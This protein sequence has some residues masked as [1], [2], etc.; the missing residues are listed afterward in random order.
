MQEGLAGD[1][2]TLERLLQ[3]PAALGIAEEEVELEIEMVQGAL[4]RLALEERLLRDGLPVLE[5]QHKA[6]GA[7]RC[8]FLCSAFTVDEAGHRPGRLFLTHRRLIFLASP[9][10][11]LPWSAATS[12]DDEDRNIVVSTVTRGVTYRFHCNSFSDARCGVLIA[13]TLMRQAKPGLQ[14]ERR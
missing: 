4:D 14:A 1:R 8:H 6:L 11:A 3:M 2:E 13:R 12:I 9:L 10:F 7:D 5:H